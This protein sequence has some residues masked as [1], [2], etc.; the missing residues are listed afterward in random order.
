MTY[1]FPTNLVKI[2]CLT[3]SIKFCVSPCTYNAKAYFPCT[4]TTVAAARVRAGRMLWMRRAWNQISNDQNDSGHRAP[5]RSGMESTDPSSPSSQKSDDSRTHGGCVPSIATVNPTDD[6]RENK[7]HWWCKRARISEKFAVSGFRCDPIRPAGMYIFA[8]SRVN[9]RQRT[10]FTLE[11]ILF[12][13]NE[14]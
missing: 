12:L 8:W 9:F 13:A 10:R 5:V 6:L 7:S 14:T 11:T 4:I 1:R 2:M 3:I